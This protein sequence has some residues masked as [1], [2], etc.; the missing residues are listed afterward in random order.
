VLWDVWL[1]G[2]AAQPQQQQQQQQQPPGKALDR[3]LATAARSLAAGG[4]LPYLEAM[5]ALVA[6][7]PS[8]VTVVHVLCVCGFLSDNQSLL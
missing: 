5:A 1:A 8:Q 3:L 7:A 6:A 2:T 4:P